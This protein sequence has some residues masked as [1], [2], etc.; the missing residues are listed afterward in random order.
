MSR[1]FLMQSTV[2]F[3]ET[4]NQVRGL[5]LLGFARIEEVQQET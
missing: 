1:W 2:R 5:H 4:P 3:R